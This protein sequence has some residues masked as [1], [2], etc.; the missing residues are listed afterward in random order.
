MAQTNIKIP[1][2]ISNGDSAHKPRVSVISKH[3]WV[4]VLESVLEMWVIPQRQKNENRYNALDHRDHVDVEVQSCLDIEVGVGATKP[5][6]RYYRRCGLYGKIESSRCYNL[7]PMSQEMVG[8]FLRKGTGP[9]K[10]I[11]REIQLKHD[12]EVSYWVEGMHAVF[13]SPRNARQ[14]VI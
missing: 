3:W 9:C 12:V 1:Q 6:F 11:F 4:W 5:S 7:M 2:K 8:R 13:W 14:T 10:W